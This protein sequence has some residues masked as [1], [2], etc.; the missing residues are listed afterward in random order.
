MKF[1]H[2]KKRHFRWL[3]LE[4]LWY[5]TYLL[6]FSW[7][8][9]IN[10]VIFEVRLSC[11][12]FAVLCTDACSLIMHIFLLFIYVHL[13]VNHILERECDL[14]FKIFSVIFENRI[15][16]FVCDCLTLHNYK[17][18]YSMSILYSLVFEL[19]V[20]ISFR[21]K[22]SLLNGTIYNLISFVK[23]NRA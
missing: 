17:M 1:F 13:E 8:L 3:S 18:L 20:F 10:N 16:T 14:F 23:K 7:Y 15:F 21:R 5:C 19:H 9:C 4:Y 6:L 2:L 22:T 12:T 11:A